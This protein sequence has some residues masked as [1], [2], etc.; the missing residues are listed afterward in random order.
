MSERVI[1][2]VLLMGD[3]EVDVMNVKQ[4]FKKVNISNPAPFASNGLK[5]LIMLDPN[6]RQI[7]KVNAE[8]DLVLLDLNMPKMGSI[9]LSQ[10]LH[11]DPHLRSTP[12]VVMTT[13]NQDQHRVKAD[14]LNLTE[15]ILKPLTFLKFV[16]IITTL[17]KY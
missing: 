13:S 14:N 5:A 6:D 15:Y 16:E 1:K 3:E 11:S 8:Q 4:A 10:E 9:E 7:P 17:N 2:I 12:I